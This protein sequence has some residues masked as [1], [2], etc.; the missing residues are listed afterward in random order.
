MG[1]LLEEED[2][3]LGQHVL[4]CSAWLNLLA[5]LQASDVGVAAVAA[6]VARQLDR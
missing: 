2:K 1:Q 5:S 6:R 3:Q 4:G